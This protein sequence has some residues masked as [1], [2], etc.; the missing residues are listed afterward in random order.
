MNTSVNDFAPERFNLTDNAAEDHEL[1]YAS[2]AASAEVSALP[3]EAVLR[4]AA[5]A[6][7]CYDS[8]W[9]DRGRDLTRGVASVLRRPERLDDE[10]S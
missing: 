3:V 9:S 6:V 7:T 4:L 10:N 1:G 2:A 8:Q 5:M